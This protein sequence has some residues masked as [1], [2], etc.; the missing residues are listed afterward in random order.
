MRVRVILNVERPLKRKTKI[1]R[2]GDAW[3]WIMFRYERLSNFCFVCGRLGHSERDC[4]IVHAN[5]DKVVDR[6]Y[7]P[8]LRAP[9]RN[10]GLNVG[11]RWLRNV[12]YI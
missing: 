4:G 2:E 6:V 5:P 10:A 7:G 11:S 9:A 3:S 12:R 1:K 8:A